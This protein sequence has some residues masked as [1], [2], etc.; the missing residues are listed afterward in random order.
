[1]RGS[2]TTVPTCEH[3]ERYLHV[4]VERITPRAHAIPCFSSFESILFSLLRVL[5]WKH[6]T[7]TLTGH[8]KHRISATLALLNKQ[9]KLTKEPRREK[10]WVGLSLTRK[11]VTA[12]LMYAVDEGTN[13]W[14]ET[15]V[16]VTSLVLM[17]ALVCRVGDLARPPKRYIEREQ[18]FLTY[19]D[20]TIAFVDDKGT[21]VTD[22]VARVRLRN[23]KGKG[24]VEHL[25][26][27]SK[28]D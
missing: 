2:L 28:L 24:S 5:T 20:V 14:T 10:Q 8:E 7:F 11:M 26:L 12:L 13:S 15:I 6:A 23:E 3:I 27:A 17:S 4:L 19:G 16:R 21:S 22:L 9:G 18:Q 1:M 25:D